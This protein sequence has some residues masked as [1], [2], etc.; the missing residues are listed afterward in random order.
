MH[1]KQMKAAQKLNLEQNVDTIEDGYKASTYMFLSC[2]GVPS[3]VVLPTNRNN[4]YCSA[5]MI[6]VKVIW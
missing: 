1:W 5:Q 4:E 3:M 2:E 6:S